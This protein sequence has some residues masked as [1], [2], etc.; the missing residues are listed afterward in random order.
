MKR[1]MAR[2]AGISCKD[3]RKYKKKG[4]WARYHEDPSNRTLRV[5]SIPILGGRGKG[6]GGGHLQ[7]AKVCAKVKEKKR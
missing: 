3:T 1:R 4:R 2:S 5:D 6:G 7:V